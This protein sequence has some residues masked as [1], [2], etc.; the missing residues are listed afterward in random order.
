[1]SVHVP[2]EFRSPSAAHELEASE[3]AFVVVVDQKHGL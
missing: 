2:P 1:M 3:D